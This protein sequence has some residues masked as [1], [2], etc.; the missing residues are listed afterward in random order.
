MSAVYKCCWSSP[1]Q[2]FSSPSPAGLMAIFYCLSFETLPTWRTRYPSLYPPGKGWPSYTPRHWVPFLSPPTTRR[3]TVA[4]FEPASTRGSTTT[5]LLVLVIGSQHRSHRK[6]LF[7]YCVFSRCQGN[8]SVHRA[9]PQQRLFYYGLT[10][11]LFP[12]IM[13][14]YQYRF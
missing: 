8:K 13:Q 14:Q 2:S 4:V 12:S 11:S 9:V 7:R 1:A 10:F 5:K 6:H 3:A